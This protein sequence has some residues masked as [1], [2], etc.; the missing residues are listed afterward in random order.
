MMSLR[1]TSLGGRVFESLRHHVGSV[2]AKLLELSLTF[3]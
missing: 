1:S 2:D 3:E